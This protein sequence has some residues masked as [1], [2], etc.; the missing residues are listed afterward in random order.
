MNFIIKKSRHY[1]DGVLGVFADEVDVGH[2]VNGPEKNSLIFNPPILGKKE[3]GEKIS[4]SFAFAELIIFLKN[5]MRENNYK[6]IYIGIHSYGFG[7]LI[8][9]QLWRDAGFKPALNPELFYL[10]I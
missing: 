4:S 2:I 5:Y 3:A 9:E 7:D 8:P 10:E 1:V 6:T